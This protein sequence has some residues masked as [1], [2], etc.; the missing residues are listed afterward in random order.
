MVYGHLSHFMGYFMGMFTMAIS[1]QIQKKVDDHPPGK[2]C[3]RWPT[4]E[5]LKKNWPICG[6]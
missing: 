6:I 3:P 2:K 4:V 1:M 5:T